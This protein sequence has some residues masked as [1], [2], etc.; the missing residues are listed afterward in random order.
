MMSI[1][2]VWAFVAMPPGW[3][4]LP[5]LICLAVGVWMARLPNR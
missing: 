3:R 2:S 1:T 5:G 4:W